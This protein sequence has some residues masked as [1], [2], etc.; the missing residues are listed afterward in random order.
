MV[1]LVPSHTALCLISQSQSH[2]NPNPSLSPIKDTRASLKSNAKLEYYITSNMVELVPRKQE[3]Q[4]DKDL[5]LDNT[6]F[7]RH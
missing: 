3:K 4:A 7:T 2:K 5:R 6:K 1:R